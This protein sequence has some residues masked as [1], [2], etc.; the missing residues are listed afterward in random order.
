M[1][2]MSE[3]SLERAEDG[4]RIRLNNGGVIVDAADQHAE[5]LYVL[6]RDMVASVTGAVSLVKA[7]QQGSRVASIGGEVR[8]QQG[9]VEKTLRSGEQVATNPK[10]ESIS[11]KEELAWSREAI[12]HTAM[13]QQATPPT[14]SSP[15]QAP[16]EERLAFEVATI[17][18]AVPPPTPAGPNARG[19]G[20]A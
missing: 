8:V 11:V 1:R 20:G 4:V 12:A 7:E 3:L 18:P 16:K 10:M 9:S 17:R 13:L 15:S 2:S 6:T 19:G 14:P 5:N